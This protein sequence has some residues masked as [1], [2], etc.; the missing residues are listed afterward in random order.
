MHSR[1]AE[2][3]AART[4][5]AHVGHCQVAILIGVASF[6][7][8]DDDLGS[9]LGDVRTGDPDRDADI[10][11]DQGGRVVDAVSGH[12]DDFTTLRV[13]LDILCPGRIRLP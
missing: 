1:A 3:I 12:R 6:R 9:S 7:I 8:D 5:P 4:N 2:S 11:P 13:R 10:G